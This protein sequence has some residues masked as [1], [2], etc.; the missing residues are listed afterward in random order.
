MT[1]VNEWLVRKVKQITK[2]NSEISRAREWSGNCLLFKMLFVSVSCIGLPYESWGHR[3]L[4]YCRSSASL[5]LKEWP[6][7]LNEQVNEE[8]MNTGHLRGCKRRTLG[9]GSGGDVVISVL[10][11]GAP[12][13]I[14]TPHQAQSLLVPLPSLALS[15]S[16]SLLHINK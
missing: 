13:C 16:L 15:F 10:W 3:H 5:L 7:G 6:C 11:N 12:H 4:E 14:G 8:L 1:L 2:F 9:F